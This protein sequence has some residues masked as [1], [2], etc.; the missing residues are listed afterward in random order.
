MGK[1]TN[2]LNHCTFL[3]IN[4][5]INVQLKTLKMAFLKPLIEK[6]CGFHAPSTPPPP[7]HFLPRVRTPTKFQAVRLAGP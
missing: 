7:P 2:P 6:F 1:I 5:Q 4:L 3:R